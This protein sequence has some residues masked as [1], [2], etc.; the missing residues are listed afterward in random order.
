[1][2]D[3][4]DKILR[5]LAKVIKRRRGKL[6]ITQLSLSIDVSKS[7]WATIEQAKRD[8]QITTLYRIAEALYIKPSQLLLEVEQELG[9]Q[10]SFLEDNVNL[11]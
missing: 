3:K 1:M 7:I 5:A 9:D 4:K 10:F 2:Q 11:V 8:A 6:S